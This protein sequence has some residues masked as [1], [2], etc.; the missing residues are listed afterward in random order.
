MTTLQLNTI[1]SFLVPNRYVCSISLA[2]FTPLSKAC[3]K[4]TS[5]TNKGTCSLKANKCHWNLDEDFSIV[6]LEK[7]VKDLRHDK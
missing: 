7:L 1:T 2:S 3:E 4:C 6:G 5:Q